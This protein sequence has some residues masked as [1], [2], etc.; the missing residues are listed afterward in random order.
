M[1]MRYLI[2]NDLP[3]CYKPQVEA[4]AQVIEDSTH[5]R[6]DLVQVGE[7]QENISKN[8]FFLPTIS[9]DKRTTGDY[10]LE[11]SRLFHSYW[12]TEDEQVTPIDVVARPDSSPLSSQL[13]AIPQGEYVLVDDDSASGFTLERVTRLLAQRGVTVKEVYLLS[14]HQAQGYE[15]I[16]DASDFIAPEANDG[17]LVVLVDGKQVRQSYLSEHVNLATRATL[18]NYLKEIIAFRLCEVSTFTHN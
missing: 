12:L 2:R 11:V 16:I 5:F 4:L 8:K 18:S 13:S 6:V 1:L 17:G 7:Q 10:K 3:A 15:D 14:Q 9:L